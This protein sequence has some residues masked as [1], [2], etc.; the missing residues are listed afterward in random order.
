MRVPIFTVAAPLLAALAFAQ[1]TPP[2]QTQQ[3]TGRPAPAMADKTAKKDKSADKDKTAGPASSDHMAE[4]QTQTYS[5]T[6]LDASCAGS[7]SSMAAAPAASADRSAPSANG[8]SC[9][10]SATTTQFA[11]KL[12]D[13]KTARFDDVGNLRAQEA[14]KA[15]KK[16][17]DEA[18]AS[19]PVH[20]KAGGVLDG[21][22]LTVV[23]I[24]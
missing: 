12:K 2:P 9:S 16:W 13:G 18:A 11:L 5:G 7:A 22:R 10:V 15:H 23:S 3:P 4:A 8:Q 17:S 1:D 19:K 21:D 20:V 6:L 24:D 14:F